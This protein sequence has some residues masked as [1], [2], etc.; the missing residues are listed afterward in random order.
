MMLQAGIAK[1]A[2]KC[3]VIEVLLPK[4]ALSV[5]PLIG[6]FVSGVRCRSPCSYSKPFEIISQVLRTDADAPRGQ[7][8]GPEVSGFDLRFKEATRASN[9]LCHFGQSHCGYFANK[10][11]IVVYIFH[12]RKVAPQCM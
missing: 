2:R 10:R 7:A 5:S 4:A 8:D 9:A 1:A 3:R 12:R 6:C 11:A